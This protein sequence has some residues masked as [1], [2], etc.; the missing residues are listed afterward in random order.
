MA[1][2]ALSELIEKPI[3]ADSI[4]E[5]RANVLNKAVRPFLSCCSA[6]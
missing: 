1:V 5:L 4:P 2:E 6:C 3:D